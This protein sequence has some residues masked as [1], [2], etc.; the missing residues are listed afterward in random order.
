MLVSIPQKRCWSQKKARQTFEPK[1]SGMI[2]SPTWS[3]ESRLLSTRTLFA[4][5]TAFEF[6]AFNAF[7]KAART[8]S[9]E[10]DSMPCQQAN[11]TMWKRLN[12]YWGE[13]W[14]NPAPKPPLNWL[15]CSQSASA[16]PSPENIK[17]SARKSS[18]EAITTWAS[19]SSGSP[20]GSATVL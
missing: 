9:W 2:S 11:M 18:S 4:L 7:S 20:V 12:N 10:C 14:D 8:L 6:A 19:S 13:P 5:D 16:S 15:L 17:L 3:L 1:I